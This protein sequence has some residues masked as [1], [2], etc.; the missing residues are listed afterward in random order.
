MSKKHICEICNKEFIKPRI[1]HPSRFCSRD[2]FFAWQRSDDGRQEYRKKTLAAQN[3]WVEKH[4]TKFGFNSAN[5]PSKTPEAR[6]KMSQF[7][8]G[9]PLPA[10]TRKKQSESLKRTL[11]SP[12][13]RKKWSEAA[14]GRKYSLDARKNM[15]RA[16][17]GKYKNRG[18]LI[19]KLD[20]IYSWYL[21]ESRQING[22][23]SCITCD[24]VF[25]AY[26]MDCGHYVSRRFMVLRYDERNTHL[27]CINCNRFQ[28]GN[29]DV[30]TIKMIHMYGPEILD[31][32]AKMRN[33]SVK[34]T[35][36]E[37]EQKLAHYMSELTRLNPQRYPLW[38]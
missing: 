16:Q 17:S 9:V 24:R 32:F 36:F 4:G 22:Q 13:M 15:S 8:K 6:S 30:Y 23:A 20:K 7:R 28:Q 1:N 3:R 12:E 2:C 18:G 31:E 19:A 21:K 33:S 29:I 10:E 25:N 38:G 34:V 37:L 14:K 11:S 5:N 26:S 35:T 27:Q